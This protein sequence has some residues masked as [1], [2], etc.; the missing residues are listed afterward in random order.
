MEPL[1]TI[2]AYIN[3][4]KKQPGCRHAQSHGFAKLF[5]K[6][7][8]NGKGPLFGRRYNS[9]AEVEKDVFPETEEIQLFH[10]K[11]CQP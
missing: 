5:Y 6:E 1:G 4:G 8:V 11:P 2:D 10:K 9:F 7:L 3:G